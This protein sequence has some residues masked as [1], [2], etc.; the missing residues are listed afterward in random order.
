MNIT[1]RRGGDK[2]TQ[3]TVKKTG[4]NR[5]SDLHKT[6]SQLPPKMIMRKFKETNIQQ[7]HRRVRRKLSPAT[8]LAR[9]AGISV[10]AEPG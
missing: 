8:W 6:M 7:L 4:I 3:R 2:P 10:L 1:P 5:N 9:I